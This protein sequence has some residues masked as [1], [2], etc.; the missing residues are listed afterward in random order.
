[1]QKPK[2]VK[3]LVPMIHASAQ[4]NVNSALWLKILRHVHTVEDKYAK[5]EI[6]TDGGGAAGEEVSGPGFDASAEPV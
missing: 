3:Q 2:S 5:D 4:T 1:M 6:D